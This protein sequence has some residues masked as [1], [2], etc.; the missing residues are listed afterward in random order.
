MPNTFTPSPNFFNSLQGGTFSPVFNNENYTF[1]VEKP[2]AFS[3]I[4]PS[5]LGIN[6]GNINPIRTQLPKTTGTLNHLRL[7]TISKTPITTG[8]LNHLRAPIRSAIDGITTGTLNHLRAPTITAPPTTGTLNYLKSPIIAVTPTK[9]PNRPTW[10]ETKRY[11]DFIKQGHSST[12]LPHLPDYYPAGKK[13][14][15]PNFWNP[16]NTYKTFIQ[17]GH[18]AETPHHLPDAAPTGIKANLP[19]FWNPSNT[20]KTFIR[21]GH[22]SK[23]PH[24][25][26]DAAPNGIEANLPNFW[27]KNNLYSNFIQIGHDS[28]V[29]HHLPEANPKGIVPNLPNFWN[30]GNTYKQFIISGH[31]PRSPHHLPE[32]NPNGIVPN[33]PNPFNQ[34]NRFEDQ[35]PN[36]DGSGFGSN[37][38]GKQL[39]LNYFYETNSGERHYSQWIKG[40]PHSEPGPQHLPGANPLNGVNGGIGYGSPNLR[41]FGGAGNYWN[42]LARYETWYNAG[43][44]DELFENTPPYR[45]GSTTIEPKQYLEEGLRPRMAITL[46]KPNE[47]FTGLD[48]VSFRETKIHVIGMSQDGNETVYSGEVERKIGANTVVTND[49]MSNKF[50]SEFQKKYIDKGYERINNSTGLDVGRIVSGNTNVQPEDELKRTAAIIGLNATAKLGSPRVIQLGAAG[51]RAGGL[52]PTDRHISVPFHR[53]KRAE[54]EVFP[55]FRARK[56]FKDAQAFAKRL[57]GTSAAARAIASGD[58]KGAILPGLYAAANMENGPYGIINLEATYGYGE[59][60]TPFALRNDFTVKSA[61]TTQW[62]TDK[63]KPT[64]DLISM[65]TPFRGDKVSVIDFKKTFLKKIYKWMPEEPNADG[66]IKKY[67]TDIEAAIDK[68]SGRMTKDLVKF[69]FT[70]QKMYAGNT[71]EADDVMV[72]RAIITSLTD[73]FNPSWTPVNFIGRADPSYNYGGYSRDINLDFTVYATDRDELK[74]IWRKLNALSGYTA[75]TYDGSSIALKGNYLRLTVGDIYHHQPI[76][77]NSLY[78][79]LH[80]SETTWETNVLEESDQMEVPKQINVSMGATMITDMIPQK[81]GRFFSLA[82]LNKDYNDGSPTPKKGDSNWLSDFKENKDL[83]N[84]DTSKT[85]VG[86]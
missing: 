2:R 9:I 46:P 15:L 38:K 5:N 84:I 12:N 40:A 31:G 4:A 80:D 58:A 39:N 86:V 62:K 37:P 63:W 56:G 21:T 17:S 68:A 34:T 19:N 57:D 50:K 76:I 13:E 47:R 35:P 82:D 8:T 85:D 24:H 33:L 26:P 6:Y 73:S 53:L 71:S 11:E 32:A 60:G 69:Y 10:F 77:I 54:F 81:G 65:V 22:A 7:P 42:S 75:P 61:A 83:F 72:F 45:I 43:G 30:P 41:S 78:Y 36:I 44:K 48:P 52:E 59:H 51:L 20:Y 27:N 74:P 25:L 70:G 3:D 18:G 23:D 66:I 49:K 1:G 79:T 55:D 28:A 67:G 29:P 14:N 64:K 16:G